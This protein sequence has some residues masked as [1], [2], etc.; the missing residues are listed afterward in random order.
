MDWNGIIHITEWKNNTVTP[1]VIGLDIAICQTKTY[2]WLTLIQI[3]LGLVFLIT[4]IN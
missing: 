1:D 4:T 3:E 2:I